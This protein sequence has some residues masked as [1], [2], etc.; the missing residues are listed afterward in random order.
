M[1][2]IAWYLVAALCE[3]GGCFAFWA[4]LRLQRSALWTLPGIVSLICFA[5]A[6]TR[7]DSANAG[8]AYAAYGGIYILSSLFWLWIVE[9][10][11]PDRWDWIGASL[12]LAGTFVILFGPRTA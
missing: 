7:I 8:R 3:I 5:V 11:P 10:T 2:S 9:S 1:T 4:W 12:C 6:L